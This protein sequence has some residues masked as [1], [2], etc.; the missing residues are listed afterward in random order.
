MARPKFGVEILLLKLKSCEEA[1]H[2]MERKILNNVAIKRSLAPT[3]T[4]N[5]PWTGQGPARK[6]KTFE[7]VWN[8]SVNKAGRPYFVD[9]L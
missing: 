7:N 6:P 2:C 8:V 5:C 1:G 3:C 4:Q 9:I